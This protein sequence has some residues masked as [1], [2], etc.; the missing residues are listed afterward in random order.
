MPQREPS[1]DWRRV[2]A[3]PYNH[4]FK[5]KVKQVRSYLGLPMDGISDTKQAWAWIEKHF[6][7]NRPQPWFV[8]M[9]APSNEKVWETDV[10]LWQVAIILI[11][12]F[13]LPLRMRNSVGLYVVINNESFLT[14]WKGLDVDF[15]INVKAATPQFA[16]TVDGIDA[17]TTEQQWREVWKTLIQPL[18]GNLGEPIP[19]NK[20][21]GRGKALRERIKR[22]AEWYELS[23]KPDSGPANAL[24]EWEKLHTKDSGKHDAST[25]S[26]A[27]QEFRRL[28]TPIPS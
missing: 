5:D 19:A 10:P 1:I 11:Y 26:K 22:Y 20:R 7:E 6:S 12:L 4:Y 17:W 18:K 16:V 3:L 23:E 13:G 9:H 24:K 2:Y 14:N 15:A 28:I 25:V 21:T 8:P 27:I